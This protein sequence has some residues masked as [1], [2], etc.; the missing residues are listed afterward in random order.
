MSPIVMVHGAF[1][2]GWSFET[3][4]E[5]FRTAG[6]AVHA[7]D[8]IGHGAD[9]SREKVVGVSMRD[10]ARQIT[11]LCAT[12]DE[13]PVLIGHSLG[14]L[15]VQMVARKVKPA[16]LVLLAPSP[17]WG[18]T[19]WSAEEAMGAMGAHLVTLLSNGAIEPSRELMRHMSLQRMSAAEAAP[20]LA[21]MR[22]ESA[23]AIRET[24]NWWLDPLMT[25]SIGP[26]P[27]PCPSLV[28]CGGKD[29]VNPPALGRR[30]AKRIGGE[31]VVLPEMSHWLLSEPGWP[32]VAERVLSW[33]DEQA[34]AAA[35]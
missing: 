21:R 18:L 10:Y 34:Q 8:L 27:L 6:H 33:L 28:I 12:F 24:L 1:V 29:R 14:G 13:P 5:P 7:P 30:V 31:F 16:G 11:K 19:S 23:R 9:E 35:A 17:P 26:G 25:T 22:P 3:F 4:A 32:A 20:V 15:V 2:G